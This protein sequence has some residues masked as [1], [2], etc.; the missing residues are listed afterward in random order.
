MTSTSHVRGSVNITLFLCFID[1]LKDEE[2][3][4]VYRHQGGIRAFFIH[5]RNSNPNSAQKI[6]EMMTEKSGKRKSPLAKGVFMS[7]NETDPIVLELEVS[8]LVRYFACPCP[9]L[10]T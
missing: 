9:C 5:V 4:N 10:S 2:I 8:R 7:T 1:I 3:Y 6:V